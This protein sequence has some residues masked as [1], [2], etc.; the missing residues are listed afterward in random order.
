MNPPLL[1]ALSHR[2]GFYEGGWVCCPYHGW[3]F[4]PLLH[5]YHNSHY[6]RK[7]QTQGCRYS[8]DRADTEPK[9]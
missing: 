6:Y 4:D 8:E 5:G 9:A 1:V 3:T 2:L 7:C